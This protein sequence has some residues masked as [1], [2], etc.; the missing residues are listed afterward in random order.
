[1]V[2]LAALGSMTISATIGT[3]ALVWSGAVK[4][5]HVT[6]AW[7]VWWTGDAMGVL[8][9]APFLLS[10]LRLRH[11]RPT[12]WARRAEAAFLLAL[13]VV[14]SIAVTRSSLSMLFVLVPFLGLTAWRFQQ[15]GAA[16]AA[17]VVAG[18]ATWAAAHDLGP[19]AHDTLFSKMLTLQAFNA[20]VACTTFVFAAIVSE[21]LRARDALQRA[22]VELEG[23]IRERTGELLEANARLAEAQHVARVGSWEWLVADNEVLWSDEMYRIHGMDRRT[24]ELSFDSA[25]ELVLPEDLPRIQENVRAGLAKR[26][27]HELPVIEYSIRRPDGVERI[28]RGRAHLEVDVDGNPA[29]MAGTV[30]DITEDKLAEREHR[31][32]ETLQRSLLPDLPEIPGIGLAARYVPAA[33]DVEVGGDWYDVLQLPDGRVGVAIGDV[34]GHGL[35]AAATMGQVRM[36]LRAYALEEDDPAGVLDRVNELIRTLPSGEMAT[37]IYLVFDPDSGVARLANA[38]HPPPLSLAD[39][40]RTAFV[41]G[42]LAPPLGAAAQGDTYRQTAVTL[43]PGSTLL[44]Y[45]DGLVEERGVPF[46]RGLERLRAAVAP[47]GDLEG[48][49]DRVLASLPAGD[50]ADDVAILAL[51]PVGFAGEPLRLTLAADPASLPPLRHVL[52][53]WLREA[54]ADPEAVQ[55]IVVA[56]N[57]ACSNAIQHPYGG[58]RGG[59]EVVVALEDG[60]VDLSVSDAGRWRHQASGQGGRGL[61][62]MEALMDTVNVERRADG[63]TVRMRRRLRAPAIP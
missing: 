7:A 19:F 61:Q 59:L 54:G 48:L 12:S 15:A 3:G 14:L 33:G 41:E 2:F 46:E 30:Q 10:L 58:G 42:G 53:R 32:A 36:A 56:C 45:T 57:E 26:R 8:V 34:A 5:S 47:G 18:A 25:V 20:T 13:L 40:G 11:R 24:T 23:R 31:I 6:S 55:A 4:A 49:C 39:D 29:R 50:R 28:L 9:V 21:R 62:I 51:R 22:A 37:A 43:G 1:I 17:L 38:G 44:L 60:G 27:D 35:R 16:P 63:T 52:R